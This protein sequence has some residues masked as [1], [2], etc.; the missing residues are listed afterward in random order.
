MASTFQSALL[1]DAETV[2][3]EPRDIAGAAVC[4]GL[5]SLIE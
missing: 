4:I 2:L 3:P 5:Q 1:G